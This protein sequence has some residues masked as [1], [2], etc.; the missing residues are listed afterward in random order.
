MIS[1]QLIL[2]SWNFCAWMETSLTSAAWYMG[3]VGF[4]EGV[5]HGRCALGTGSAKRRGCLEFNALFNPLTWK[6][7]AYLVSP[8]EFQDQVVAKMLT[9]DSCEHLQ[10]IMA[11]MAQALKSLIPN[12]GVV[13]M[14]EDLV[15]FIL[16][17]LHVAF[18]W[19]LHRWPFFAH[20]KP[21]SKR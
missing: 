8:V 19:T 9:C 1:T 17:W 12:R 3:L 11:A 13:H 7:L 14:E 20:G 5:N 16:E 4:H 21:K 2:P 6:M 15:L 18:L 10:Q